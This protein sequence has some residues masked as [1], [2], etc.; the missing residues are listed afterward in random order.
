M[1][2]IH[3]E[4]KVK[5]ESVT[6]TLL[7][8]FFVITAVGGGVLGL[9][10]SLWALAVGMLL[11]MVGIVDPPRPE[12][13]AA[14]AECGSAGIR[15]RMIT[16]DHAVTAGAIAD[17]LGIEG[18]AITGAEWAAMSDQEAASQIDQSRRRLGWRSRRT[19]ARPGRPRGC[20]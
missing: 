18:R 5:R 17:E 10:E 8:A 13:K 3:K 11:A 4:P 12:A 6:Q 7:V 2:E 16:G 14:I 1:A 9:A 20:S 15:V 19:R